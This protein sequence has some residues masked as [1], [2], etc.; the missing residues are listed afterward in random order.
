VQF[1]FGPDQGA[2]VQALQSGEL[3][4]VPGL[5]AQLA[6][7]VKTASNLKLL[8]NIS[9]MH[10]VIHM[11]SDSGHAASDNRVRQ[12]LKL[13]TDHQAM[14]DAVR[15]GLAE[16]GNG[17]PVGPIFK[18]Y[19]L[20]KAPVT[21]VDQAK[22]LLADAG[23]TGL[24]LTLI[25]QNAGDVPSIATVWKAQMAKIGVTVN[26]QTVP[27]DVYYGEGDQSWLK[28][29]FS[30]TDWGTRAT[31]VQYF[32]DA[33]V[34]GATYNESHWSDPEFDQ[35]TKQIGSELDPAKRA[36]LYKQ[37]QQILIE[38]GPVI[39]PYMVKPVAGINASV[40]GV[41]LASDWP[42]TAFRT[43]SLTK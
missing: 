18:D 7:Q 25:A 37:A 10:W 11:R 9:N 2:Q 40:E 30:I 39:V 15:P 6:D 23:K 5:T 12:A 16:V 34:T 32:K 28:A 31:P 20:D 26:I 19:Y 36:A 4:F 27:V 29:D 24:T 42:R 14:I 21:N 33:Y 38:R 13:G 17:T 35:L 22:K 1:I 43:A 41:A 3:D 8:E